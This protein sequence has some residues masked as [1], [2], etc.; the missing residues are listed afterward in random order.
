MLIQS[1]DDCLALQRSAASQ[2]QHFSSRKHHSTRP[3]RPLSSPCRWKERSAG[4]RS[5]RERLGLLGDPLWN[6][7]DRTGLPRVKLYRL[8]RSGSASSGLQSA[9]GTH[10][11]CLFLLR[12]PPVT[13]GGRG[14]S[15]HN[16]VF[17]SR[18]TALEWTDQKRGQNHSRG[19]VKP[20]L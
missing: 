6:G 1:G 17:G 15:F 10:R 19:E 18:G 12:G 8:I 16:R 14:P 7:S 20:V 9:A 3:Q 4:R 13:P 5:R 2:N 11:C